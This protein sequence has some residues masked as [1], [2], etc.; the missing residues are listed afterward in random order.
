MTGIWLQTQAWLAPAT[1]LLSPM[2]LGKVAWILLQEKVS[3][4]FKRPAGDSKV[5]S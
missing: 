2:V 4:V 5:F 1:D 3:Q